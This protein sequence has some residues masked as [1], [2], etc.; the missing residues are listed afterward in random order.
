MPPRAGARG[1][2]AQAHGLTL[3]CRRLPVDQEEG[4]QTCC[5]E[6]LFG[7]V[8]AAPRGKTN[9]FLVV[10][11]NNRGREGLF[12]DLCRWPLHKEM[13]TVS[14]VIKHLFTQQD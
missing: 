11:P 2:W 6:R 8:A 13:Q 9:A 4:L 1:V 5:S 7:A 14:W 3:A 12:L 10:F